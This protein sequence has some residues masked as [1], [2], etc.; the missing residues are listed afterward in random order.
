MSDF[1]V[2]SICNR[3]PSEPYYCLNEWEKSLQGHQPLII[4]SMDSY[5]QGLGDKPKFVYRAIKRNL[6]PEKYIIFCD[7]WDLVFAAKPE[8]LLS[9]YHR[10]FN[11]P[12]VISAEK[13]CFPADLK[14]NYD[15]L[16]YTSSYK[17]LN[18]GMIVGE[19][20]ALLETL[21]AMDL[22]NVQD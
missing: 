16:D 1:R 3:F 19:T 18:S 12:L 17:Y 2:V 14:D 9:Y 7:C 15:N 6:I 22:D 20:A 10:W 4:Q 8:D 21:E 13:N 5:Y 11:S